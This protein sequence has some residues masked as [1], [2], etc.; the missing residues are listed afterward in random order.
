[1][2]CCLSELVSSR[3]RLRERQ[4]IALLG[5]LRAFGIPCTA[6][7]FWGGFLSRVQPTVA[8]CCTQKGARGCKRAEPAAR[9]PALLLFAVR[10]IPAFQYLNNE[11]LLADSCEGLGWC[12][13]GE[14]EHSPD[15]VSGVDVSLEVILQPPEFSSCFQLAVALFLTFCPG[16]LYSWTQL[17]SRSIWI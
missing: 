17:S 14:E 8:V 5:H 15:Q 1:M 7:R 11:K 9:V 2:L 10:F 12:V 13:L 3:V 4:H 6:P 16:L